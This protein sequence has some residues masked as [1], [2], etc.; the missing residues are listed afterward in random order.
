MNL[1]WVLGAAGETL[2]CF[3]KFGDHNEDVLTCL[4]NRD[5]KTKAAS[6]AGGL[7][8]AAINGVK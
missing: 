4:A 1:T 7:G 6:A 3:K 2:S 8:I 5:P